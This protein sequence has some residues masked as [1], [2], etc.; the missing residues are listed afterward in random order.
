VFSH[1]T[2][3]A[4]DLEKSAGFYDALLIPLGLKRRLVTPDGGPSAACWASPG[5]ALP[6]FYVYSP[7]DRMPASAGNGS[8]VAFLAPDSAAVDL[9]YAAGIAA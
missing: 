7:Y 4:S 8:M 2:V 1:V 5:C 9:A 6:R 3:G